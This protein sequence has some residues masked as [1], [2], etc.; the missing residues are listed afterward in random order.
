MILGFFIFKSEFL[1]F[2]LNYV[3]LFKFFGVAIIL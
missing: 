2:I 1:L 3:Y